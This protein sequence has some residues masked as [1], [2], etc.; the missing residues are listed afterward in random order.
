MSQHFY[1]TQFQE[2]DIQVMLGWDRPLQRFFLVITYQNE[3]DYDEDDDFGEVVY[4]NLN[5][6]N[7][8]DGDPKYQSLDYF[9]SVLSYFEILLPNEMLLNVYKD[10]L[11]NEGNKE[12]FYN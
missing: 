6:K 3:Q 8:P 9:K 2:K 11:N 4:S 1:N 5:D 10:K 12:V 7:L